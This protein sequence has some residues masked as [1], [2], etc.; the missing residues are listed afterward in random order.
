MNPTIPYKANDTYKSYR[1]VFYDASLWISDFDFFKTELLFL[2][3]LLKSNSFKSNIPNLFERLQLLI[4]EVDQFTEEN[5]ILNKKAKHLSNF[6]GGIIKK[7][8][9][10]FNDD[11]LEQYHNLAAEVF[12]FAQKYKNFK[13][14]LYEFLSE[15][16][17]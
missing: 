11:Y 2:K 17:L 10:S 15:I 5:N 8:V 9:F 14:G 12:L 3:V 6:V 1:E 4:K 13:R 16:I 7:D